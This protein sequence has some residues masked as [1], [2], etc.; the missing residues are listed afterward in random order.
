[1]TI[2]ALSWNFAHFLANNAVKDDD[3]RES[4]EEDKPLAK[5]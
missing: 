3:M 2:L 4:S 1:M 5:G